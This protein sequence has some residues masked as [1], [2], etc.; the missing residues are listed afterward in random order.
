M[1]DP[2]YQPPE[3]ACE[4]LL[5]ICAANPTLNN[6]ARVLGCL[7]ARYNFDETYTRIRHNLYFSTWDV[8]SVPCQHEEKEQPFKYANVR[9]FTYEFC[10]RE[11]LIK[12]KTAR[13]TAHIILTE[14]E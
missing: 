14:N 11:L 7:K 5:R 6:R 13:T 4:Y 9:K 10:N 3:H 2:N 1:S 8:A 12:I